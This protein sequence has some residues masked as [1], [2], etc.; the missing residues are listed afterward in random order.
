[1]MDRREESSTVKN[2]TLQK[3][4]RPGLKQE[5]YVQVDL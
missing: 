3:E 4:D 5:S 2:G 1:M